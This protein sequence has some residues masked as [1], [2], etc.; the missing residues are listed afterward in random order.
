MLVRE[1]KIEGGVASRLYGLV[2]NYGQ[3]WLKPAMWLTIL[4][5]AV[6]PLLHLANSGQIPSSHDQVVGLFTGE[7]GTCS[8]GTDGTAL[9]AA[10]ELSVKNALIVAADNDARAKRISDCLFQGASASGLRGA[11][12]TGLEALQTILTL[13]MVFFIG[14]A[15][16]RRLQMR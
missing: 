4:S 10:I 12:T 8:G 16:R 14:A 9:G 15:I 3:S 1:L 11:V 7:F 5:L 2:S 6:F 13:V